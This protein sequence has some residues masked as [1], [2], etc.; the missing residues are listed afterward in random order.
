M[1]PDG[2]NSGLSRRRVLGYAAAGFTGLGTTALADESTHRQSDPDG[3]IITFPEC[4]KAIVEGD[5]ALIFYTGIEYLKSGPQGFRD[6]QGT[7]KDGITVLDDSGKSNPIV[8]R[9]V[10]LHYKKNPDP[11]LATG[12]V[13]FR[14]N[15][16]L[17]Q[18]KKNMSGNSSL[19]SH[20]IV[21]FGGGGQTRHQYSFTVEGTI[22]PSGSAGGAPIADK[23]VG[24]NGGS[25][26]Y[27]DEIT[28]NGQTA[29][30]WVAGGGDAYDFTGDIKQSSWDGATVYLDGN[31]IN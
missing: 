9:D 7:A 27:A 12:Y 6:T 25:G 20:H 26:K 2:H 19:N 23:H 16:N 5:W 14:E 1:S 15:P 22:S 13:Y 4:D 21:V 28:N 18:C 31:Q 24:F 30:G 29:K 8:I 17:K 11:D 3:H 10:R